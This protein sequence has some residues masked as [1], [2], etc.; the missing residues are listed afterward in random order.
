MLTSSTLLK[1]RLLLNAIAAFCIAAPLC[2]QQNPA[3]TVNVNAVNL[4]A[5]VRDKHRTK[6]QEAS[7]QPVYAQG[8]PVASRMWRQVLNVINDPAVVFV[9]GD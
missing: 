8:V 9:L 5:T 3:I 4:L 2:S 7:C 1:L 6:Y